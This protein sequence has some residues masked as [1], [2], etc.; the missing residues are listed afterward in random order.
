MPD[1]TTNE[2][3]EKC[4]QGVHWIYFKRATYNVREQYLFS[5]AN[6]CTNIE[7]RLSDFKNLAISRKQWIHIGH[8]HLAC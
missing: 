5:V 6:I 7:E 3:G 2:N 1:L 4:N 8:F